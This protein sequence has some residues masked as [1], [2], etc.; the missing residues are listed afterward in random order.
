M[1]I[2]HT[3][4]TSFRG[5]TL[6]ELLVVIAI[7]AILASILF[8]VFARARENARRASC[9]SNLK[10]IGLG[11]MMYVQDYDEKYPRS[12]FTSAQEPPNGCWYSSGGC[13]SGSPGNYTW[14][15]E[16]TIY[17]YTKSDQL[18]R[19]PSGSASSSIYSSNYGAN[20]QVLQRNSSVALAAIDSP[21]TTY[22]AMDAGTYYMQIEASKNYVMEPSGWYWYLPGTHKYTT[23]DPTGCNSTYPFSGFTY[24]D[25][26]GDG[27]H[28][29]GNNVIYTD[30]HVKWTKTA[31]MWNEAVKFKNGGYTQSTQS[32]WNPYNSN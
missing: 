30:G 17:P 2:H 25:F 5:F 1:K 32:A 14:F 20:S 22:M 8:P 28:F 10:Q 11:I 16:Q 12:V 6:I 7:I 31:A 4:Q 26:N 3:R 19:C 9:M 23:C 21:A 18:Y 29:D 27:R 15:W 13:T 24:S